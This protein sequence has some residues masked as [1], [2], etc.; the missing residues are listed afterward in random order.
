[1]GKAKYRS[2]YQAISMK[3]GLKKGSKCRRL[4][5][6]GCKILHES[7]GKS[8]LASNITDFDAVSPTS[9]FHNLVNCLKRKVKMS[10][11]AK[12]VIRWFK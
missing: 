12:R 5:V 3:W 4:K 6:M 2:V 10:H 9:P 1:M 7:I 11:L 8:A